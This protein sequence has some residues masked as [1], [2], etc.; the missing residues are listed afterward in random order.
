MEDFMAAKP[1]AE[2]IRL[3]QQSDAVAGPQ[4]QPGEA[5]PKKEAA[6]DPRTA[7]QDP[8]SKTE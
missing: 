6:P 2:H 8:V 1:P 5:P 4:Q 7:S 3:P